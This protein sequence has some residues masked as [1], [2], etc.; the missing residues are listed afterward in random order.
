MSAEKK[1]PR[2]GDIS[3]LSFMEIVVMDEVTKNG[4]AVLLECFSDEE[5]EALSSRAAQTT[6][7]FLALKRALVRMAARL[8]GRESLREKDFVLA[9][10]EKGAPRILSMPGSAEL[11][12][13]SFLENLKVSITHTKKHACAVAVYQ[14]TI[15]A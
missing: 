7:G 13:A 14:E 8:T 6:A 4:P 12:P 5:K 10:D 15:H 9:H 1:N 2:R 3:V 11:D